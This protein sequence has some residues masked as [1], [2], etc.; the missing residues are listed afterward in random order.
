[1]IENK[2]NFKNLSPFKFFMLETFPFIEQDYFDALN[3]W[4]LF[5]KIGEKINEIINSQNSVGEEVQLLAEAFN[6]LKDYVDEFFDDLSVQDEVNNKLNEMVED[7]TLEELIGDKVIKKLDYYKITTEMTEDDIIDIINIESPKVI[8]FE[9]G[10]YNFTKE[11]RFTSNTTFLLNNAELKKG[12]KLFFS[13]DENSTY[14]KY[15]GIHNVKFLGG[16]LDSSIILMHAKNITFDGVEFTGDIIGHA[17]QIASCSNITIKNCVFNGMVSSETP[18]LKE[19]IQLEFCSYNGQP[20][21]PQDSVIYDG[22]PNE[23]ITIEN[24]TFNR[25][26]TFY[27]AIGTHSTVGAES[28]FNNHVIIRNNFFHGAK[29]SPIHLMGFNDVYIERNIFE[30]NGACEYTI[31]ISSFNSNIHILKNV[32][33]LGKKGIFIAKYN[34]TY[35]QIE[36]IEIVDNKINSLVADDNTVAIT[37]ANTLNA[38]II[39]NRIESFK[40]SAFE[41][42]GDETTRNVDTELRNNYIVQSTNSENGITAYVNSGQNIRF[43]DNFIN[44]A[45]DKNALVFDT[46]VLNVSIKNNTCTAVDKLIDK[47]NLPSSMNRIFDT[48]VLILDGENSTSIEDVVPLI[49][50]NQFDTLYVNIGTSAER[51]WIEIFSSTNPTHIIFGLQRYKG[52]VVDRNDNITPF[53]LTIKE[54]GTISYSGSLGLRG[55][56]GV[57]RNWNS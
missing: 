16:K 43:I 27:K 10:I 24:C 1:M 48:P 45:N 44:C 4:Q 56:F 28:T 19:L 47:N 52:V 12:D 3:E 33:R 13:Y 30:N 35:S 29:Y 5:C 54:D 18:S 11:I 6:Q 36:N 50:V 42:L 41:F 21:A 20:Y 2:Y 55:V 34:S 51:N 57:N 39:N 46:S 32:I 31:L 15:N 9:D 17:M 53:T 40:R 23:Y 49:P 26:E 25:T 7:G 22:T 8:E 14:T 37:L 38:D